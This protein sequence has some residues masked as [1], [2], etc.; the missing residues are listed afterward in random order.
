MNTELYAILEAL[1]LAT[2]V[3]RTER[4]QIFKIVDTLWKNV[5]I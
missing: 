2:G 5:H 1:A 4:G 3:E